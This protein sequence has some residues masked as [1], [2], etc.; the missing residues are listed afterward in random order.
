MSGRQPKMVGGTDAFQSRLDRR[1]ALRP[2]EGGRL[3]GR[4]LE[5]LCR[6]NSQRRLPRSRLRLQRKRLLPALRRETRH[7]DEGHGRRSSGRKDRE[8]IQTDPRRGTCPQSPGEEIRAGGRL[9]QIRARRQGIRVQN[10]A[11][12]QL[13]QL[14]Q[15]FLRIPLRDQ[16]HR[17]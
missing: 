9:V 17:T 16:I 4:G 5:H 11:D 14:P 13:L 6:Q 10:Q 3:R 8:R 2:D 1:D 12:E 15:A 7:A